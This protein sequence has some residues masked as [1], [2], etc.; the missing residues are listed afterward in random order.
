VCVCAC[1]PALSYAFNCLL[2][3]LRNKDDCKRRRRKGDELTVSLIIVTLS[4][5]SFSYLVILYYLQ[6]INLK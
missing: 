3:S 4:E 6:I 1:V 2:T 5:L